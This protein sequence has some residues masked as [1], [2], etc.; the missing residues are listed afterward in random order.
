MIFFKRKF[1]IN[2]RETPTDDMGPKKKFRKFSPKIR[3]FEILAFS[4]ISG[5]LSKFQKWSDFDETWHKC[6]LDLEG[7][8]TGQIGASKAMLRLWEPKTGLKKAKN[9]VLTHL[10]FLKVLP[11]LLDV[12]LVKFWWFSFF[13]FQNPTSVAKMSFVFQIINT[14]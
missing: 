3:D 6:Q 12:F 1:G 10:S 11:T 5:L 4:A 13:Y 9:D 2:D 7:L 14:L 8:I